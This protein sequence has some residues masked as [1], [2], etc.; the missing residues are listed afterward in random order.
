MELNLRSKILSC[1]LIV[2][3]SSCALATPFGDCLDELEELSGYP[4]SGRTR[5]QLIH[6]YNNER[7]AVQGADLDGSH[8]SFN[9]NKRILM[10]EWARYN[11]VRSWPTYGYSTENRERGDNL[12]AHHIIPQ[13]YNG[14]NVWWNLVPLTNFKHHHNVHKDDSMC[15]NVFHKARGNGRENEDYLN[16]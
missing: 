8:D 12:D 14:P 7:H 15:D 10:T 1:L 2:L 6:H 9:A 16:N 3:F 5:E 13:S 11:H 4:M